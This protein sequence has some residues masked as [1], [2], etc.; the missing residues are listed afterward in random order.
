MATVTMGIGAEDIA[1]QTVAW[2]QRMMATVAPGNRSLQQNR[3]E[4]RWNRDRRQKRIEEPQQVE[5]VDLQPP[6]QNIRTTG[7]SHLS[8]SHSAENATVPLKPRRQHVGGI[9]T[10]LEPPIKVAQKHLRKQVRYAEPERLRFWV[11]ILRVEVIREAAWNRHQ[12][13]QLR[14]MR[15]VVA[16]QQREL[17]ASRLAIERLK[18]SL[19]RAKIEKD[20]REDIRVITQRVLESVGMPSSNGQDQEN[21]RLVAELGCLKE[22]NAAL[23]ASGGTNIVTAVE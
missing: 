21:A 8:Q 13:E 12:E 9:S 4:G 22:E 17:I 3:Q 15:Q 6:H 11:R 7:R 14:Q 10:Q 16:A 19:V 1:Q 23:R 2:A 5:E 20:H 18:G